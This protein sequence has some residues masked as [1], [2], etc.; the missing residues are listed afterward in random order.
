MPKIYTSEKDERVI[1]KVLK[2]GLC[3]PVSKWMVLR[4]ALAI[5]L[6][7]P[8]EPSDEFDKGIKGGKE[9]KFE[10]LTGESQK[11]DYTDSFCALL[12]VYHQKDLFK[13]TDQY[14][15][16]LQRHARRGLRE[17]RTAWK[18]SHDFHEYLYQELFSNLI[19]QQQEMD[20]DIEEQVKNALREIGVK[21]EIRNI[22]NG[23]RLTRFY[24][25]LPNI[26][27]LDRLQKGLDKIS[28]YLG[29][30]KH[31]V[32][33]NLTDEP[34]IIGLDVPR[35]ASTW[36]YF[37]GGDLREWA[38]EPPIDYILPVWP[39]VDVLGEPICFDLAEAPHLLVGGTTGSGK[40]VCLH[41]LILSIL[42]NN[43][44]SNLTLCLIDPKAVEFSQ[45]KGL[46]NLYN[47]EIVT[48]VF[49]A[50]NLLSD[51]VTEMSE[52]EQKFAKSN[53]TNLTEATLAG[54]TGLPRIVVIVEELADL[55]IQKQDIEGPLIRLLQ[56]GRSAGI[57]LVLATQRP[58]ST[59]FSG[60]LR[61]N[62]PSRIA[63]TVQKS[64]ESKII[65]DETGAERLT[66]K[67]DMLCRWLGK[68]VIRIHGVHI[69]RD[70][71]ASTLKTISQR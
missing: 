46:K 25:Y 48:E 47:N 67:G 66:G 32:F 17:I 24:I 23:P 65:I 54:I 50:H 34:R 36:H 6:R 28:F 19:S 4:I 49:D 51:L 41:A 59:T 63:L 10:Q 15:I 1:D 40:S 22:V 18:E 2:K 8:T 3:E 44:N 53:V 39:G 12:S 58:D 56:K 7:I 26:N 57:H 14:R 31:R 70:D 52:R 16:Y 11:P 21:S 55:L 42:H 45:Y 60:L 71:I 35:P 27:D 29:L 61:S 5:S 9:Y 33:K 38:A 64:T 68:S 69:R 62:V 13:N 37:T 20:E 30:G 43:Y